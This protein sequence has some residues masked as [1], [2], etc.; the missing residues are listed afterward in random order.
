MVLDDTELWGGIRSGDEQALG[1]LMK[2]YYRT[3][4]HYGTKF[5]PDVALLE[6]CL[7]ELFVGLWQRQESL[8]SSVSVRLYLFKAYHNQL[9]KALDRAGRSPSA[10][11][12]D[13]YPDQTQTIEDTLMWQETELATH[14]RLQTGLAALSAR[15]RQV[16]Y[17]RYYENLSGEQVADLMGIS[18]QSV[19]NLLQQ[20]LHKLRLFW[21]FSCLVLML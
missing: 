18:R 7:Q 9:L 20:A 12:T 19:A 14:H 11:L 10:E 6:D 21:L 16:V 5:T 17:L 13:E 3:L 8:P 15:Q 1:Y 2:R 4:V